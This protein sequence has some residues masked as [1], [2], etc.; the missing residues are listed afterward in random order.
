M[1]TKTS[2]FFVFSALS[3]IILAAC[4]IGQ[5]SSAFAEDQS[6]VL[7]KVKEKYRDFDKEVN[8]MVIEMTITST[9]PGGGQEK[10]VMKRTTYKKG[11]KVRMDSD[12][13]SS[14]PPTSDTKSVLIYDGK[15]AWEITP[16]GKQKLPEE[17]KA[18]FQSERNWWDKLSERAKVL[19]EE[20]VNG[21]DAYVIEITPS[22]TDKGAQPAKIWLD[23]TELVMLQAESKTPDGKTLKW[24]FSG[25]KPVKRWEMPEETQMYM[26]GELLSTS[27]IK[28]IKIDQDIPE[29]L[30]DPDK[31]KF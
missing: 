18:Q 3:F 15:D 28:S 9:A 10:T 12:L 1:K 4:L 7:E 8:N 17:A 30:F 21:K 22:A 25:F 20:K 31:V 26:D 14:N 24:T 13:V 6:A 19:G 11:D 23:K 27:V 5:P 2:G 29:S 16:A